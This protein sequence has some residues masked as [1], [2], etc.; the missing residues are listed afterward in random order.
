LF[1]MCTAQFLLYE[2]PHKLFDRFLKS[3]H[4]QKNKTVF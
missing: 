4:D 2:C 3:Y 1:F